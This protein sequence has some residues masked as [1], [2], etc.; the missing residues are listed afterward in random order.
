MGGVPLE[1][2]AG[3]PKWAYWFCSKFSPLLFYDFNN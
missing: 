2:E 1:S 3:D